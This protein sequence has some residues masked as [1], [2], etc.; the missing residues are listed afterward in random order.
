LYLSGWGGEAADQ[1]GHY[2]HAVVSTQ[3]N[4][5][6][7]TVSKNS[8]VNGNRDVRI[9]WDQADCLKSPLPL[10]IEICGRLRVA[11]VDKN[12]P[13][14]NSVEPRTSAMSSPI[15]RT[16]TRAPA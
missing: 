7:R 4:T 16:K 3:R 9:C 14:V 2:L 8:K 13:L 5:S 1:A 10:A 12:A 6:K 15:A 11:P